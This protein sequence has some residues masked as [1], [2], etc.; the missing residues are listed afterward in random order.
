MHQHSFEVCS[1][2]SVFCSKSACLSQEVAP[3]A[4]LSNLEQCGQTGRSVIPCNRFEQLQDRELYITP[5]WCYQRH[6]MPVAYELPGFRTVREPLIRNRSWI[7]DNK[8]LTSTWNEMN[9]SG[10]VRL[11]VTRERKSILPCLA[12]GTCP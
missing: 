8:N 10:D 7:S 3:P 11:R 9:C 1:L 6:G 2:I 4:V 12:S 5:S